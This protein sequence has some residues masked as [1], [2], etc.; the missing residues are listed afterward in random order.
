[1]LQNSDSG[2]ALMSEDKAVTGARR[3]AHMSASEVLLSAPLYL[4]LELTLPVMKQLFYVGFKFDAHCTG[5]KRPAP[6]VVRKSTTHFNDVEKLNA[7]VMADGISR[8]QAHC[9]R[10]DHTY[11]YWLLTT[12]GMVRKIGQHPSLEDIAGADIEKYRGQLR[13]GAFAELR[14]ATGLA[15]HGIGIGAFVYLR[16]IFE[17]LIEEHRVQVEAANGPIADWVRLRMTEKIE[18]LSSVL[19]SALVKHKAAYGILSK[20]LH[21]L[22]EDECKLYF[23]AVRA[24]IIQMLEED[25][26]QRERRAK[27]ADLERQLQSIAQQLGAAKPG[28]AERP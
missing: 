22:S 1:M 3:Q 19:P 12:D 20:G 6:F 25:W 9:Q 13:D 15:S 4:D 27:E 18:A 10:H 16:R 2:G 8:V 7:W 11:E 21:E 26:I 23:P 17:R 5:C 24:A 14:R 28:E